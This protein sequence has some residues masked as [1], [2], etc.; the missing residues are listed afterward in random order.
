MLYICA[1]PIGN[2]NDITLR[3][4]EILNKAD[5]ILCEDTRMSQRLLQHHG[6]NGKHLVALHDHNEN[7][8]GQ[9]VI[10][11]LKQGMCIVQISD[12]GTPGISDPGARLCNLAFEHGFTPIPLPGACAYASL[13]SVAG[14]VDINCLFS[15][16]LSNKSTQ[17]Q[18]QMAKWI[19][20]DFAVCIYE[21]PHR[22]IE[23]LNDIITILGEDRLIIMGRE[24]TKQFETIQKL[25]A[26]ELLKFV[27]AD[28]NQQRGE[29]ALIIMPEKI[30]NDN[31]NENLTQDQINILTLIAKELPT[32][33]AVNLTHK[34]TGGNKEIMYNYLVDS[35]M[36][37][38]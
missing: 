37:N 11:W 36:R 28:S 15:G 35:K 22:I 24:L 17:R 14:L 27:S 31:E 34:L 9:K 38:Q 19:S 25:Q 20:V 29:F 18:K 10:E 8:A 6:I 23:C 30:K 4:L 2:L 5:I 32:K 7:E 16:F 26:K 33:K 21:S 3:A 1:T 13:L 12:A